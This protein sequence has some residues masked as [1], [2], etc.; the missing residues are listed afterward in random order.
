MPFSILT[1]ERFRRDP[2]VLVFD[3]PEM[4]RNHVSDIVARDIE[5]IYEGGHDYTEDETRAIAEILEI[6]ERPLFNVVTITVFVR[7][8][9][10]PLERNG[11]LKNLLFRH[12]QEFNHSEGV[13]PGQLTSLRNIVGT[14]RFYDGSAHGSGFIVTFHRMG[15]NVLAPRYFTTFGAV[16]DAIKPEI[17]ME[18]G[19]KVTL[20]AAKGD[21]STQPVATYDVV[22]D[23]WIKV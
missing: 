21:S 7:D 6:M 1:V 2:E 14:A 19:I 15:S 16:Q 10:A 12:N 3:T 8:V 20:W 22:E 23:A 17:L 18:M 11:G 9:L 13:Q 4:L 5:A